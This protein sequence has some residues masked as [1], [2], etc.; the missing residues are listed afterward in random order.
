MHTLA[1]RGPLRPGGAYVVYGATEE[2]QSFD[3]WRVL[4]KGLNVHGAPFD[5]RCFPMNRTACVLDLAV[6][7]IDTGTISTTGIVTT[8][9]D[10][11]DTEKVIAAF[12]DY[13]QEG[14]MKT[15]IRWA[16]EQPE[17]CALERATP[18]FGLADMTA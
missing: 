3:L 1:G 4:A 16:Q 9:V 15:S 17:V 10:S 14:A 8:S 7:L 2:P 5:V 12:A 18:V 6:R 13:G 11:T